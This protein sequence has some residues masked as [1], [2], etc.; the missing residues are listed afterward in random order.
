MQQHQQ[1]QKIQTCSSLEKSNF[2]KIEIPRLVTPT[3]LL[4]TASSSSS[5]ASST[6]SSCQLTDKSCT[7][8]YE[9]F[10]SLTKPAPTSTSSRGVDIM[11]M[12][13]K[14]QL[15]YTQLQSDSSS[16]FLN[17][18]TSPQPLLEKW[19]TDLISA[20]TEFVK[21]TTGEQAHLPISLNLSSMLA[22]SPSASSASSSSTGYST[23]SSTSSAAGFQANQA[24]KKLN[25]ILQKLLHQAPN[26]QAGNK[27]ANDLLS[28][29]LKQKLNIKPSNVQQLASSTMITT[30][31]NPLILSG[32][33]ELH[34]A[35]S[36]ILKRP[37]T[38]KDFE[39]NLLNESSTSTPANANISTSPPQAQQKPLAMFYIGNE[40]ISNFMRPNSLVVSKKDS[41]KA[42]QAG[43]SSSSS[44]K[45]TYVYSSGSEQSSAASTLSSRSRASSSSSSSDSSSSS[46]SSD[47][48]SSGSSSS[49]SA[50]SSS[51]SPRRALPL[52]LTPAAFETSSISSSA[53]T[54][55]SSKT[56][57]FNDFLNSQLMSSIDHQQKLANKLHNKH[58]HHHHGKHAATSS[59]KQK[60][61]LV[62][63]DNTQPD[64]ATTTS[65][66]LVQHYTVLNK[67]QLQHVLIHLLTVNYFLFIF[68]FEF[69]LI[70]KFGILKKE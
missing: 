64:A 55:S 65:N 16:C 10:F 67:P 27:L 2:K 66:D 8:A 57:I 17:A 40:S 24:Q 18:A 50:S 42:H 39:E 31:S 22:L 59:H 61:N 14:A 19:S 23:S 13:T 29:E 28:A 51:S 4:E 5:S 52:L 69:W 49:S 25:P 38:L 45:K 7:S 35:D 12:L 15:E 11:Q 63:A 68:E 32:H 34:L 41:K 70:E 30:P 62:F 54:S 44:K 33:S 58:H 47:S 37:M 26:H 56:N 6:S 46:T 53:S 21:P 43:S 48:S 20:E 9:Q 60:N 36:A 3:L 1:Q